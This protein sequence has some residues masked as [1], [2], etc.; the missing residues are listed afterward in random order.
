MKDT[1]LNYFKDNYKLFYQN[2]LNDRETLSG[3][4]YRAICAFHEDTN[5]S[6]SFNNRTGKWYCHGCNEGGYVSKFYGKVNGL[7]TK[8]DF[9]KIVKGK[10][11]NDQDSK[12][13]HRLMIETDDGET[14]SFY[15]PREKVKMHKKIVLEY[16]DKRH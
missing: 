1:I 7:N 11:R 4:E 5:P 3:D 16:A 12:R 10:F 8:N 14:S 9:K 2:Y 13:F 15:K 6:L